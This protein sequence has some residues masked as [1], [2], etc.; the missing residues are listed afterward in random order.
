MRR[1]PWIPLPSVHTRAHQI[2]IATI[3]VSI[4]QGLLTQSGSYPLLFSPFRT[5]FRF[6]LWRPFTALFV[7]V[8]PLEVIFGAMIIYSVGGMLEYRLGR[9]RMTAVAL[10]IPLIAEVLLL[11]GALLLPSVFTGQYYAGSRQ[12]VTTLWIVFGL[13][14]YFS[15]EMLNFWG[16][17]ITGRTFAL[18]GVGF[19]VLTGV[20]GNFGLVLPDLITI[21]LCYLYMYRGG[22]AG[23]IRKI[24][25][26][27]YEWKLQRLK[28]KSGFR[29]IKGSKASDDDDDT[30]HQIH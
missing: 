10:G 7:A 21:T 6:E 2:A 14:A 22:S 29:V 9:K 30:G 11:L 27:Y 13:L 28:N 19:V 20:F 25:L 5:V 18:I 26:R 1:N 24:E 3:I 17:P 15:G 4:I 8:G 16:T 23:I 12:V